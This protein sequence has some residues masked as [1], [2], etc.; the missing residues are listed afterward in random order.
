MAQQVAHEVKNPL[1]PIKLG[2]QHIRRAWE[3]KEPDFP[4]VLDRNVDVI[5]GEIDRLASVAS[6]FSRFAAPSPV[7]EVPLESILIPDVVGEVLDLYRAGGGPVTFEFRG[8]AELP[9]VRARGDEFKEVLVNLL[10]NA[11]AALPDGGRVEVEAESTG[12]EVE[13]RVHDDG[14][15]IPSDVLTRVFEPHFSTRATGSGLGLAIVRRLVDS[16]GG[17]VQAKSEP[18]RGTVISL[19]LQPWR[20]DGRAPHWDS[21]PRGG[22]PSSN[23]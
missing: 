20:D 4:K 23:S 21:S 19:R 5:L 2:I 3:G 8:A 9:P 15:G 1:T 7:G 12:G 13:V 11:R 16:W 22:A 17:R 14:T 18:G 6:S 10:E